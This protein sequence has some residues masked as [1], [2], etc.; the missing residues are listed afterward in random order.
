MPAKTASTT[1]AYTWD[2]SLL[3]KPKIRINYCIT[4]FHEKLH[5]HK[6]HSLRNWFLNR[7]REVQKW[8]SLISEPFKSHVPHLIYTLLLFNHDKES[9]L[10]ILLKRPTFCFWCNRRKQCG[11]SD[12]S[13]CRSSYPRTWSPFCVMIQTCCFSRDQL[14]H[15]FTFL[16]P[17]LAK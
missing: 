3:Q 12:P 16:L 9:Q 6:W 2:K 15:T 14:H 7:M 11:L 17:R 5:A 8:N 1:A 10:L 13:M 4:R